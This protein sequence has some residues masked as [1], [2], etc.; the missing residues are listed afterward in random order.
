MLQR[1]INS[2]Q[3]ISCY[4][5]YPRFQASTVATRPTKSNLKKLRRALGYLKRCP[6]LCL[7]FNGN[8][9]QGKVELSVYGDSDRAGQPKNADDIFTKSVAMK[10]FIKPRNVLFGEEF[11]ELYERNVE[12]FFIPDD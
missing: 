7:T 8:K 9:I 4:P 12:K 2:P 5:T 3:R 6:D 11:T 10:T 1:Y